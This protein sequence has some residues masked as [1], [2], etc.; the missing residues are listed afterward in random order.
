MIL[1]SELWLV[2]PSP[3][4][5][6]LD[7]VLVRV[8]VRSMA[9]ESM[10]AREVSWLSPCTSEDLL[11]P[12]RTFLRPF[13]GGDDDGVVGV[14]CER[15]GVDRVAIKPLVVCTNGTDTRRSHEDVVSVLLW[16]RGLDVV[17]G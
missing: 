1:C 16:S 5:L 10:E 3:S 7:R 17:T 2:R 8:G 9:R 4:R 11:R 6:G 13:K 14:G 15:L 12:E